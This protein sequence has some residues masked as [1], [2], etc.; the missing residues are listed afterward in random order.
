MHVM[1]NNNNMNEKVL[2]AVDS[3]TR[4][5]LKVKNNDKKI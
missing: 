1:T 2:S 5:R 3:T 4:A